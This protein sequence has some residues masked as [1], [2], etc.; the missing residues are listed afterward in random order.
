MPQVDVN[1]LAV[2]VAAVLQ[3][4]LG[5]LW[6]GPLFGKQWMGF[7][8]ITPAQISQQGGMTRTYAWSAVMSLITAYVLS[9][10]VDYMGARTVGAG[11]AAGFWPWL[12]FVVPVT[13]SGLL[14]E[15][16]PFGLW[17]LNAGYQLVSLALMGA[18]LAV[19]A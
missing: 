1:Y 16:R 11:I 6:Y 3:M 14:Y 15:N 5:F 9:L 2:I 12:G 18:L 4:V 10:L 8:K 7:M 13:A 17:V 19:W